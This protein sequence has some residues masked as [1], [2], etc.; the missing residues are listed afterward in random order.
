ME[1]STKVNKRLPRSFEKTDSLEQSLEK[2][3]TD[4]LL[5]GSAHIALR[6][7]FGLSGVLDR[8]RL[9]VGLVK[10]EVGGL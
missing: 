3:C 6:I 5:R 9:E 2:N 4:F 10:I 7:V 8:G 1:I